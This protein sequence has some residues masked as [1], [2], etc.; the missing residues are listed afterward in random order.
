MKQAVFVPKGPEN[1]KMWGRQDTFI[2]K[3]QEREQ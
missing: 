2:D 1:S 3:E